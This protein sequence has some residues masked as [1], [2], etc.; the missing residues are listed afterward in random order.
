MDEGSTDGTLELLSKYPNVHIQQV[1]GG[2]AVARQKGIET[3]ETDWHLHLDS[4]VVLC[5][6]WQEK[7]ERLIAD[8]VGAIW[9]VD[10]PMN[11]HVLNRVIPMRYVR[12]MDIPSLM[13]RNARIRGG[14]HDTLVRTTL[15]KDIN[16]PPDLHIFEDWYIKRHIEKKSYRFL[17]VIEPYC[18]HYSNPNFSPQVCRQIATLHKKYN[19]QSFSTTTKYFLLAPAKCLAILL[20]TQDQIAMKNQWSFYW[21]V[22]KARLGLELGISTEHK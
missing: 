1:S 9:G 22:F 21:R 4:D 12:G 7:A 18:Y 2:R 15:V 14:T 16:I 3:V 20:L 19:I 6:G 10:I 8:D 5:D 13:I 17:T 11:P